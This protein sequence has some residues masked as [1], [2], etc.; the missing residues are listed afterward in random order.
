MK[1]TSS[2]RGIYPARIQKES[3]G[4]SLSPHLKRR[5]PRNNPF[6]TAGDRLF[7]PLFR[8]VLHRFFSVS[9]S[10]PF[11]RSLLSRP[12]SHLPL[13]HP[14]LRPFLPFPRGVSLAATRTFAFVHVSQ[15]LVSL[16]YSSS[17]AFLSL[18]HVSIPTDGEKITITNFGNSI[19]RANREKDRYNFY[20]LSFLLNK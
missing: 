2:R 18:E 5:P 9:P 15:Q 12:P 19:V 6:R 1:R 14:L 16:F 20:L 8:Y 10:R 17:S 4:F 7:N 13:P 11:F 3:T